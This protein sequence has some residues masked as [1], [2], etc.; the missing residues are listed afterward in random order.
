MYPQYNNN[1]KER[2]TRQDKTLELLLQRDTEMMVG[3]T[4]PFCRPQP[5]VRWQNKEPLRSFPSAHYGGVWRGVRSLQPT[6]GISWTCTGH[7]SQPT[8]QGR[9]VLGTEPIRPP[10]LSM[11]TPT[12]N[13]NPSE[14]TWQTL[15]SSGTT[16]H[17][18]SSYIAP[19]V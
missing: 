2:K 9:E 5:P 3:S 14:A 8:P 6:L 4:S 1:K 17:S 7:S 12:P 11:G 15:S 13:P 10:V 16:T 19:A 18:P